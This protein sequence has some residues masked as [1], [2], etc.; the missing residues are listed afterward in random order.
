MGYE[1]NIRQPPTIFVT[2]TSKN[3]IS[4]CEKIQAYC[5]HLELSAL[6]TYDEL[7]IPSSSLLHVDNVDN[8]YTGNMIHHHN[9]R[10]RIILSHNMKRTGGMG[11]FLD[12]YWLPILNLYTHF[13][14]NF[15]NTNPYR[16]NHKHPV[17][18]LTFPFSYSTIHPSC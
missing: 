12:L 9:M 11:P 14:K 7:P 18:T 1:D 2:I 17:P 3:V 8:L 13:P 15:Q 10:C 16:S 6:I 5:S 4:P